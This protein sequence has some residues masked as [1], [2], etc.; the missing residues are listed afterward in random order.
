MGVGETDG[1]YIIISDLGLGRLCTVHTFTGY[2]SRQNTAMY[3]FNNIPL[4][5]PVRLPIRLEYRAVR[6]SKV[7]GDTCITESLYL[8]I[9]L[10]AVGGMYGL[11]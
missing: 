5:T 8:S 2:H 10:R 6:Q 3:K 1:H 7:T 4:S 9:I 11:V